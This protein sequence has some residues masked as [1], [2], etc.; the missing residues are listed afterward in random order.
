LAAALGF[1]VVAM[2]G[3]GETTDDYSDPGEN[4]I[5]FNSGERW[6]LKDEPQTR[7]AQELPDHPRRP[8]IHRGKGIRLG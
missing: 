8:S 5:E 6:V 1:A 7:N 4:T 3:E 2:L